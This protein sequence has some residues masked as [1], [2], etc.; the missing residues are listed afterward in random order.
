VPLCFIRCNIARDEF[1]PC[2]VH[3]IDLV[4]DTHLAANPDGAVTFAIAGGGS[5]EGHQVSLRSA[6]FS[7]ASSTVQ[8]F[9]RTRTGLRFIGLS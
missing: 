3:G 4:A 7:A 2:D 9:A 6:A 5:Q 1:A 8:L